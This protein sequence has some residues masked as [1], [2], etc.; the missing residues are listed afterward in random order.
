MNSTNT[1]QPPAR[2]WSIGQHAETF[3]PATARTA[4]W[5]LTCDHASPKLPA[6]LC[7]AA[8]DLRLAGTHWSF[9]LGAAQLTRELALLLKVPAVLARF[10]RLLADANRRETAPEIFRPQ[11]EGPVALNADR[12]TSTLESRLSRYYRPYHD[13]VRQQ[14]LAAPQ[15]I[16]VG[17]HTYT[18]EPN[19]QE[20][21][22]EIGILFN[23][24]EELAHRL[25]HALQNCGFR[26][27]M[28]EPYSGYDD[29]M[30]GVQ[31]HGEALGRPYFSLEIRQDLAC[32]RETRNAIANALANA[33]RSLA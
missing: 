4:R 14:A 32:N 30:W 26:I 13:A 16:L 28:N 2:A 19:G 18:P 33:L 20:R 23:A 11:A 7:W 10:S 5:L 29:L 1:S 15:A 6:P 9:D 17:M 31:Q 24:H 21:Q 3:C 25:E 8:D 22:M 27:A 12:S